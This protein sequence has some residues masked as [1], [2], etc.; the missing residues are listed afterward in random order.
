MREELSRWSRWVH[1]QVEAVVS[2]QGSRVAR[3]PNEE[4]LKN[5][6]GVVAAI[7]ELCKTD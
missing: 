5:L 1:Q 3:F 7:G 4:V 6:D 2:R